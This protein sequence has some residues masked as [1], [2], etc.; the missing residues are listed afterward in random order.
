MQKVELTRD[1]KQ[2]EEGKVLTKA[3][4]P[5][6]TLKFLVSQGWAVDLSNDQPEPDKPTMSNTKK[7]IENYLQAHKIEYSEYATKQELLDLIE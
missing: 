5:S 2:Y 7:E 6:Y 3:D 4:R 1:W